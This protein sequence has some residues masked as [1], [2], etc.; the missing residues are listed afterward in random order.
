[1]RRSVR[2]EMHVMILKQ[3]LVNVGEVLS[4]VSS[5][6]TWSAQDYEVEVI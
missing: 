1:M 2:L 6:R 3:K 5:V 4:N